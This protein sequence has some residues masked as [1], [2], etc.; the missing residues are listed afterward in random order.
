MKHFA[1]HKKTICIEIF[2]EVLEITK[3]KSTETRLKKLVD[4]RLKDE[5][6]K[7]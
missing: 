3:E 7:Y 4:K 5:K 1:R 6:G 2:S